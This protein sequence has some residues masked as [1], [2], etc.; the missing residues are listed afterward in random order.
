[1]QQVF[2]QIAIV[3]PS[4]APVLITGES[5]AGKEQVAQTIHEHSLRKSGPFIPI[6]L[7]ALSEPVV[8]SELFGHVRGAFTGAESNRTGLLELATA[9]R[10][11][12]TRSA[13]FLSRSK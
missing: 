3:A 13:T 2:K 10:C 1:M 9:E 4:D 11:C 12:W 6:C 8:E 5:G 7:G